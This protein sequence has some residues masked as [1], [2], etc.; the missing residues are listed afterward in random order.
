MVESAA[1]LGLSRLS[2]MGSDRSLD[3][4]KATRTGAALRVG[5]GELS[6]R[7]RFQRAVTEIG[8]HLAPTARHDTQ[9]RS[10]YAAVCESRAAGFV[11]LAGGLW[12]AVDQR[13]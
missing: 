3:Y 6:Q 11:W 7:R 9:A 2:F 12:W 10:M 13:R 4:A 8:H 1:V 5:L